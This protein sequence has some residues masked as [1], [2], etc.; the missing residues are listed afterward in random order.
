M[1]TQTPNHLTTHTHKYTNTHTHT[2]T[3]THTLTLTLAHVFG[4][5]YIYVYLQTFRTISVQCTALAALEGIDL[6][7]QRLQ[8][9]E[10]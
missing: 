5:T 10:K 4:Y 7:M 9:E 1:H 8:I 2:H 6:E 3:H